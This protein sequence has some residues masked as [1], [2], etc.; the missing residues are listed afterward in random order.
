MCM[1]KSLVKGVYYVSKQAIW[2]RAQHTRLCTLYSTQRTG[3]MPSACLLA[4]R[5]GGV[6]TWLVVM[7][8][9]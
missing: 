5:P 7:L 3:C 9:G 8:H 2:T 6:D 4:I 1:N